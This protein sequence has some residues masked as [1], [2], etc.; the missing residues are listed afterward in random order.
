MEREGDVKNTRGPPC[1]SM[2]LLFCFY[3]IFC[4]NVVAEKIAIVLAF[5]FTLSVFLSTIY[6]WVRCSR[7]VIW[8]L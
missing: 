5:Q 1:A 2:V 7:R 6:C 8:E 3:S 4:T